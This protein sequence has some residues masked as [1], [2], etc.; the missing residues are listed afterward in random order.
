MRL[1]FSK[2]TL[3]RAA[4]IGGVAVIA[5]AGIFYKTTHYKA[6]E[7][8]LA[9]N[10]HWVPFNSMALGFSFIYVN[11]TDDSS[12]SVRPVGNTI[13]LVNRKEAANPVK[14]GA[15]MIDT[16]N[17]DANESIEDAV[18]KQ[19]VLTDDCSI[20]STREA[21]LTDS[22]KE[23]YKIVD[24]SRGKTG[25]GAFAS[26]KGLRY[27][28]YHPKESTKRFLF[29]RRDGDF[30]AAFDPQSIK[31]LPDQA[32]DTYRAQEKNRQQKAK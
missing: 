4:I 22:D 26:N 17:K 5:A 18:K 12:M 19:F 20:E 10:C 32:V 6:A 31:L 14:Y 8:S 30:A 11:C 27:V 1:T 28:E 21:G 16:F 7:V 13:Y 25:C 24:H 23:T 9:E 15:P 29:V 2:T 3:T